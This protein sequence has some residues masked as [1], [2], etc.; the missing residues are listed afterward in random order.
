MAIFHKLVNISLKLIRTIVYWSLQ[1]EPSLKAMLI[2]SLTP[3]GHTKSFL[4]TP[5]FSQ[6]PK[7]IQET[8]EVKARFHPSI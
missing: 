5:I 1:A 6:V 3:N 2:V 8:L 7:E 4:A